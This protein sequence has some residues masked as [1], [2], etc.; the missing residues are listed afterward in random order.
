[1]TRT[2]VLVAAFLLTAVDLPATAAQP[3]TINAILSLTG[4]GAFLGHAE[5]V[6][7]KAAEAVINKTGG[8]RGRPVQ[9]TIADDQSSTVLAVQLANDLIAQNVAVMIGPTLS[10]TC[11]AISPII[12][13]SGPVEYCVS[14]GIHPAA[15]SYAFST[16]MSVRDSIR[17]ALRYFHTRGW[18]RVGLLATIDATGQEGEQDVRELLALPENR[19]L[20]LVAVEHLNTT[21]LSSSAQITR[22][23]AANPDVFITWMTGTPFGLVLKQISQN[24]FEVPVMSPSGNAITVQLAQYIPFFPK[25]LYFSSLVGLGGDVLRPGPIRDASKLFNAALRAQG[26]TPDNGYVFAWDPAMLLVDAL[27]HL[28]PDATATQIRDYLEQLHGFA[29]INGIY[30]FRD[31]SQRGLGINAEMVI[32]WDIPTKRWVPVT[33]P[34]G[35]KL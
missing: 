5:Q 24:G 34:A 3:Y 12:N 10:A 17:G 2:L 14:P 21:D 32:R 26:V 9:F 13:K 6:T 18:H 22:I 11:S 15:D 8:I 20:S 19:D 31:G 4:S 1:M 16:S 7:L 25:E 29:G 28:G 23:Q 33:G 30:D 35:R 27:R